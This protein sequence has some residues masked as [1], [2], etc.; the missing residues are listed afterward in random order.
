MKFVAIRSNVKE[1]I[2]TIERAAG[3]N[4]NLP[5]LK[6]A[7]IEAGSNGITLTATNLELA[8]TSYV[9]GK[10]IESGKITAP[11]A[12]LSNLITNIQSDRLNFGKKGNTLEIKTDNYNA[13]LQGLAADD[14]PITPKIK[15]A[16]EYLEIKAVLLKEAIQ[17][18]VV[19]S[20]FSDLRPEL[21]AI[22]FD[23]SLDML[24][25]AATDGFR[26]A[27]KS[28]PQNVF[29]AKFSEPFRI[30]IPLKTSQE[31]VRMAKDD[32]TVRIF[33][34]E[35]QV[36][37]K[38]DRAELISRL[39]EGSF[40]DYSA[41]IPKKFSTEVTVNR[42]EFANAIKLAGVFGQKTSELKLAVHPQK[43]ALEV[44][45]ADQALGENNY[46]LPAKI[47][48]EMAETFF[49]W[50]YLA[51]PVRAMKTEE[52]FIGFQEE[53]NPALLRPMGDSSYYY[54]LKP[55]LKS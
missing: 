36:L 21:N 10:V 55:I 38:T 11:L 23:F 33:R 16:E 4:L 18:V 22:L 7:L 19:A 26:L 34:D 17:Q 49:N 6:N 15:S 37:F 43:K 32:E 41:I 45:S 14:F 51:D 3:E 42:E 1:A 46:L 50:R 54:V 13:T 40:P 2:S 30:L 29:T 25:L 53:T 12:L 39:T 9:S 27:E 44:S 24:K 20:Q 8:I 5:I 47:K 52:I 35:S 28:L 48:G 31:V